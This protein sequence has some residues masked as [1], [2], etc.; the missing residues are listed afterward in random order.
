MESPSVTGWHVVVPVKGGLDAKSR[1]RRSLDDENL[2]T[3]I[4]RDTLD[5]AARVVGAGHVV[6]VTSDRDETAYARQCG[7]AVVGDPGRGLDPACT[8]GV[9]AARA[10]GAG[11]VAIL[12]GD[13]PGLTEDELA[14]ALATGLPHDTFFVPDAEGTGTALLG[15]SLT[16]VPAPAFGPGS[17]ARHLALGHRRLDLDLPGLRHDVD[18]EVSLRHAVSHLRV[19]PR[20]LAA[21]GR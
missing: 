4:V 7:H 21:L 10:R 18:D 12:L 6:V 11:P 13:H 17:A 15:S 20:T 5:V 14:T 9:R 19:G 3:A 1:L 2:V 8:A 16:T